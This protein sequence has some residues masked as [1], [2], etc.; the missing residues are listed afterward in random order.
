MRESGLEI[1]AVVA[2]SERV[3]DVEAYIRDRKITYPVLHDPTGV[4]TK[5]WGAGGIATAFLLD[6]EGRIVWQGRIGPQGDAAGCEAAIRGQLK[7]RAGTLARET[8]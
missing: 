2:E 4:N 1:V 7:G 6:R 8:R 3:E 5:A